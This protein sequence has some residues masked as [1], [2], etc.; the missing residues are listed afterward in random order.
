MGVVTGKKYICDR[1]SKT[2]FVESQY[3]N[4]VLP[5]D[6]FTCKMLTDD[7]LLCPSCYD[8][9]DILVTDFL[10]YRSNRIDN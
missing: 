4:S 10:N 6:W 1:C 8:D 3:G 2:I 9:A 7:L 5:V